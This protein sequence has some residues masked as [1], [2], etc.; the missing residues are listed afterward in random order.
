MRAI[1][2]CLL[3]VGCR[4]LWIPEEAFPRVATRL[5]RVLGITFKLPKL[6]VLT[7]AQWIARPGTAERQPDF[8]ALWNALGIVP[9][10]VDPVA[11]FR[12]VERRFRGYY[13]FAEHEV[14]YIT[15]TPR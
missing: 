14:V 11:D 1:L 4:K 2:L 13:D 8:D 15:D 5:Q 12:A 6:T 3:L 7:R 9:A 10:S